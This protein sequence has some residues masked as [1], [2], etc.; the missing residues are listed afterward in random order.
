MPIGQDESSR[1]LWA[2]GFTFTA[3]QSFASA[4]VASANEEWRTT[5]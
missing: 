5:T 2:N 3:S 1:E 4:E